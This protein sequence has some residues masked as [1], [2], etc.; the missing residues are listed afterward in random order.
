LDEGVLIDEVVLG[1]VS[2]N[3]VASE[4]GLIGEL[5]VTQGALVDVWEVCLCVKC[6]QDGVVRPEGAIDAEVTAWEL[7]VLG[8]V[9]D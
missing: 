1:F 5:S 9:L 2:P 3:G 8:H 6:S 7:W 4:G